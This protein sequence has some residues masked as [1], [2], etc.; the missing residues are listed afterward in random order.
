MVGRIE[1]Y[2]LIGDTH[3]AALVGNG[4]LDRL[5]VRAPLRLGR[6]ASPRCS[7][8]D[9]TGAGCSRRPA[10][11][12]ARRAQL[13]RRH[14]R[15]RDDVPHRRR[16]RRA[17]PTAC[18]S[19]ARPSTRARRRRACPGRVPMQH[20]LAIR[21][22]YGSI[23]PWVRRRRDGR[24]HAIAGPDARRPH[25]AGRTLA[26]RATATVA[27]F[28]VERGRAGA[29]RPDVAP[30]ARA[31]RRV[32]STPSGGCDDDRRW[33][34]R[35][36]RQCTYEGESRASTCMRSLITL[37]ALTYAPTGGIVAAPTTS[38]PERIG[39]VRNWDYRYC[40]LRDSTLTLDRADRRRA[41]RRG[42]GVAR[43]AAARRRRRPRRRCRSC[44][45]SPAS[46]G[47]PSSSSTGSRATRAR[48]R[49]ASA[50]PRSGQFQ[51]DVYGEVLDVA[52]PDAP[53]ARRTP[54]ATHDAWALEVALLEFL[55]GA[56]HEPDDG[57][58]EVRGPA[59]ALHALEG[60]GVG[61][62]RPRGAARSSSSASTGPV[63]RW[64]QLR[65]EIHAEVCAEGFD[66]SS[67]R[68]PS[69]TA[70]AQL[71]ASLLLIPLVGF[72]PADD[73][74]V[75]RHRRRDRAR[76][77]RTTASCCATAP[78]TAVDGLP[79]GEGVF[80]AC[81]FWLADVYVHAGPRRRG[82][83]AV[84]A[85]ARA[86]QR[87]RPARRGVRPGAERQLGN[88][89]QAFTHLAFVRAAANLA[90]AQQAT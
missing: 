64:R 69:R 3:T 71:D 24:L 81:S 88:F 17:S 78:T 41:T 45:A 35:W 54:T 56:W 74:R 40:W 1:D 15:A 25:D 50:T 55:E 30:V 37:K 29:V 83:G 12:R 27:D 14:A 18:R 19:G 20:G 31:G 32:P 5:A 9:D 26:A 80:L 57:I 16:R 36:S 72:L 85:A 28:V 7:A 73:P 2:A 46:A 90:R 79:A 65:D 44:T 68:S 61:R 34:R 51:L 63:D 70:R 87:R 42:A 82:A 53:R 21:F 4:R 58:W 33:W 48:S 39:G 10:A 23:V 49:C 38:L 59:P 67:T 11:I 52:V 86:A 47:S 66:P 75:R 6:R 77:A 76:A 84:R 13:P 43:L 62:V 22:D 89:P 60:D 8:P